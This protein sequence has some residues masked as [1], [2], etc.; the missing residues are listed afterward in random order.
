MASLEVALVAA[1]LASVDRPQTLGF[2]GAMRAF[3]GDRRALTR[4]LAGGAGPATRGYKTA[5]ENLRRWEG[6]L[7]QPSAASRA[8]LAGAA[9][10]AQ[11][12][13]VLEAWRTR[14]VTVDLRGSVGFGGPDY[15]RARAIPGVYVPETAMRHVVRALREG[16]SADAGR[17]FGEA[18]AA[19]YI[20]E[21]GGT[22][23]GLSDAALRRVER[24]A[25]E[26]GG[27]TLADFGDDLDLTIRPG[28]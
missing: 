21:G 20:R 12:R 28:F 8:R 14:G 22:F 10:T 24:A 26:S 27:G 17:A 6:G 18:W 11:L 23:A 1:A 7:R 16:R 9:S 15:L 3:R 2:R 4:E 25:R 19:A 13:D 5:A